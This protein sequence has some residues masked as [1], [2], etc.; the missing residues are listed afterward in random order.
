MVMVNFVWKIAYVTH[1]G[2]PLY[3][4]PSLH[5]AVRDHQSHLLRYGA[6]TLS[7]EDSAARP[8]SRGYFVEY[9]R[10]ILNAHEIK[11]SR[12]CAVLVLYPAALTRS[13]LDQGRNS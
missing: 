7:P 6:I 11:L 12:T 1:A 10:D 8:A 3:D 4:L 5:P 13:M 2:P 9:T